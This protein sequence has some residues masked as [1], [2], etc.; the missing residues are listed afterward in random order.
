MN[1][2]GKLILGLLIVAFL[3]VALPTGSAHLIGLG[4]ALIVFP[5]VVIYKIIAF[6]CNGIKSLVSSPKNTPTSDNV[7]EY[8][9]D[10]V[11]SDIRRFKY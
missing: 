3:I 11:R 9:Y 8:N 6:I 4:V 1:N 5:F 2:I 7:A 10:D